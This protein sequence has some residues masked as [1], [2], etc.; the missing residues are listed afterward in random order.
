[1]RRSC[2]AVCASTLVALGVAASG[3]LAAPGFQGENGSPPALDARDGR[4]T[5]S[6]QQRSLASGLEVTWNRFGTPHSVAPESGYLATG[7]A[8]HTAPPPRQWIAR[9]RALLGID[10]RGLEVVTATGHSVLLRQT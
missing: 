1:M 7:L 10:A 5:P 3:A 9:N 4:V 6:A 8:P 2:L